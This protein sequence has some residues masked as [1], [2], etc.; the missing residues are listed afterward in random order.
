MVMRGWHEATAPGLPGNLLQDNENGNR[1]TSYINKIRPR[2][3]MAKALDFGP[4]Q[5]I[6]LEIPGSTPGVVD[7]YS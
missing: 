5:L 2:G 1:E 7:E 6:T 3:L 4:Q